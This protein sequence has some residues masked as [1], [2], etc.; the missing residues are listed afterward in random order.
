MYANPDWTPVPDVVRYGQILRSAIILLAASESLYGTLD[1]ATERTAKSM[2]DTMLRVAWDR[3]LGGFH[4]AGSSL[5]P[6]RL[7]DR[8]VFVR[9]KVWWA[10]ADGLRA[11]VAMAARYPDDPMEYASEYMRLW[12][13]VKTYVI[14]SKRGGWRSAG[15]DTNREARKRPKASVWK[16]ASHEI[17]AL[18]ELL[19]MLN[20]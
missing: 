19:R 1:P 18:L 9:D 4:L 6:M 3:E 7:E 8:I 2:V 20:R 5:G 12:K 15:V 13:Y 11:L 14:D 17:E 16:D 10:Q